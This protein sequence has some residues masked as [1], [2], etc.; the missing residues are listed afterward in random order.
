MTIRLY[1]LFALLL[2]VLSCGKGTLEEIPNERVLISLPAKDSIVIIDPVNQQEI[3]RQKVGKLPHNIRRSKD[4]KKTYVAIVGSQSIAELDSSDGTLLRT[5]LTDPVPMKNNDGNSIEAHER[6]NAENHQ[7]CFDCHHSSQGGV[8]PVIVGT[9]PFGFTLLDNNQLAVANTLNATVNFIDLVTGEISRSLKV[10][11]V[12]DA[13]EPT[14]I[15]VVNQRLYVTV[16]PTLPS[17]SPS[18]LNA[19]DLDSGALLAQVNVGSAVADLKVDA[20]LQRI[21]VSNFES[22][23]V[24]SFNLELEPIENMTVENGPM[25]LTLGNNQLFVANYYNNSVSRIDLLT[26][27]IISKPLQFN[28]HQYSNPTHLKLNGSGSL[29]YLISGATKGF[30]LV[31]EPENLSVISSMQIDELPFD[32]T[33]LN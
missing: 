9:R 21:Y 16:R 30:L 5:F 3:S 29:I 11:P 24:D 4:G 26:S 31:L 27:S 6:E 20:Q 23:R 13:H 25:G 14:E 15:E 18:V 10:E 8:K 32:I 12:G 17:Q 2:S 33:S 7:S 1:C 19:Y 22:N 28:D